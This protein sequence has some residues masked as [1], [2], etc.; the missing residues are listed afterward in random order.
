LVNCHRNCSATYDLANRLTA[1]TATGVT[2]SPTWDANGNLSNDG[3]RSYSWDAR[4]RLSAIPG[5]ASFVYDGFGRRQTATRGGTATSFLY[6]FWDVAQEQQGGSPSADLL[7]GLG[8]D[9]RFSRSGATFLTDGLGSTA[10]LASSG[11]VQTSYGYD[12]YG[13]AQITGAASDDSFQFTGRENDGTG[14]LNYRNRYYNPA[15][16]RFVS[17]DRIGLAGGINV[18][19]YSNNNP[20]QLGDPSGNNAIVIGGGIGTL[21]EPGLGTAIGAGIGAVI[22]AGTLFCYFSGA[23]SPPTPPARP[24]SP[25]PCA[26]DTVSCVKADPGP[27][28]SGKN[29]DCQKVRDPDSEKEDGT[30]GIAPDPTQP[31]KFLCLDCYTKTFG[32]K[33]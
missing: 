32:E 9:E 16:G 7:L 17:E 11:A 3:V 5:V 29:S 19:A 22:T 8:I 21:I 15:W 14:L 4:D 25:D 2:A 27:P 1:R 10:A 26:S 13:A 20:V 12:P 33:P 28:C 31:G 23:C 6:D 24:T 30:R 18:Y